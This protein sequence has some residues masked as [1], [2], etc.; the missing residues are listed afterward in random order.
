MQ[1][2]HLVYAR[3]LPTE[4]GSAAHADVSFARS[5]TWHATITPRVDALPSADQGSAAHADVSY[6][7]QCLVTRARRYELFLLR[8]ST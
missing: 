4:P 3:G 7:S 2:L 8:V 6:D 5:A 1:P